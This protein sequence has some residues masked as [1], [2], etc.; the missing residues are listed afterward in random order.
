MLTKYL[1]NDDAAPNCKWF[2]AQDAMRRNANNK[3]HYSQTEQR[4]VVTWLDLLDNVYNYNESFINYRQKFITIKLAN[5]RVKNRAL[6][7]EV[8]EI[9]DTYAVVK[10]ITPQGINYRFN[11]A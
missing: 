6:L 2:A 4:Q 8:E 1:A 3:S 10:T 5:A 9:L 11:K 7:S